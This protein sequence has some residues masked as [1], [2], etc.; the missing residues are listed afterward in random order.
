MV[1]AAPKNIL[2][3][4]LG[5]SGFEAAQLA[6]EKCE[7]VVVLDTYQSTSLQN[8]ASCLTQKGAAVFTGINLADFK[9]PYQ[10]DLIVISPGIDP[11][12]DFG[13]FLYNLKIPVIGEL[14][15]ASRFIKTPLIGITG[16]NG[17]TTTVELIT[18]CLSK[19]GKKVIAAGNIGLALSKVARENQH[20]DYIVVEVSSFQLEAIDTIQFISSA[21]L[22]ISSDHVDR[23]D[24]FEDYGNTKLKI[25]E[26]SEKTTAT[27]D[28]LT[29]WNIKKENTRIIKPLKNSQIEVDGQQFDFSEHPMTG[30]HNAENLAVCL[31]VL[32]HCGF[33]LEE[34]YKMSLSYRMA[35][36]RM[37]KILEHRGILF[38]NDSKA[39]NPHALLMALKSL[40]EID[41][42][43][44]VLIAGGRDKKMD[45]KI[46]N[47]ALCSYT[48]EVYLY[49]ECRAGLYEVWKDETSCIICDDFSEAVQKALKSV[50]NG[51]TLLLSPGCSSLDS[52]RN[53]EDRGN[54]FVKNVQEWTENE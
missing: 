5:I 29:K 18:H 20:L 38:I 6:L 48:K 19:L 53:Y 15:F 22:N 54:T 10:P 49:G 42:R 4:G 32:N 16:T 45:F 50:K 23:Y 8:R 39:T 11:R 37:Q 3:A 43:N 30:I 27:Q 33:S 26:H 41:K 14:E 51:E 21:I 52:F 9:L 28:L 24:S 44:I 7:N 46:V 34:V 13:K 12:S 47:T 25:F 31:S 35:P 40:G 1:K 36:H 17:K 2:I